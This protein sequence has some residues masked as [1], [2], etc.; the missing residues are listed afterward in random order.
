MDGCLSALAF[1]ALQVHDLH[2]NVAQTKRVRLEK[3]TNFVRPFAIHFLVES[4]LFSIIL[5]GKNCQSSSRKK[6]SFML[7]SM[8]KSYSSSCSLITRIIA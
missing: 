8:L 3:S 7:F 2:E 4:S 1:L 6:T 5:S